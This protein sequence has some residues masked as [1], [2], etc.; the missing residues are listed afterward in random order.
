MT[1]VIVV[2]ACTTEEPI[3]RMKCSM[4]NPIS[5]EVPENE[6]IFS[7]QFRD[8]LSLNETFNLHVR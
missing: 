1:S 8:Y 4:L 6:M 2:I 5:F 3:Y 7:K